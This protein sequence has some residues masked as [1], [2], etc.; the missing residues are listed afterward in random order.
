MST[1]VFAALKN[2][3]FWLDSINL[4][5]PLTENLQ[6][7]SWMY[8]NPDEF[9]A[10][11]TMGDPTLLTFASAGRENAK[12]I[13]VETIEKLEHNYLFDDANHLDFYH[14]QQEERRWFPEVLSTCRASNYNMEGNSNTVGEFQLYIQKSC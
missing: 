3:N 11:F 5:K 8:G 10:R 1:R 7:L 6:Y 14:Q 4:E 9:Y 13:Y 12:P 2:V